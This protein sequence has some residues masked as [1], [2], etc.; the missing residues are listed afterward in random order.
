MTTA[1]QEI[2]AVPVTAPDPDPLANGDAALSDSARLRRLESRLDA[3]ATQVAR[4]GEQMEFLAEEA[5][6]ARRRR[7]EMEDLQSDL[8]PVARDL[9]AVIVA[10]LEE[11]QAYVQLEDVLHLLKRLARNTHS[12]NALLDQLESLQDLGRDLGPIT[13]EM[14][15]QAVT[16]LDQLEQKGYFGFARQSFYVAD[17]IVT[18]F[19]EEDV[20][21]LGDNIVTILNTVKALTQP[22]MMQLVRNL[23]AAYQ[24]TGAQELPS[25]L[26][27]LLREMRD[28]QVR[29]GL[30][31][32]MAMLKRIAAQTPTTT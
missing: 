8:M 14:F 19:S 25:G 2:A 26:W 10:Q 13:K 3:L 9:Y 23:T 15:A 32:T 21:L 11:I 30:A 28:P 1:V 24:E 7:Q 4:L 17:R 31:L 18:A 22:E 29:R 27:G 20:R 6:A 16:V 12:V 5:Y